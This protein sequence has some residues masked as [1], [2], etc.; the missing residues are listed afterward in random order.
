[1]FLCK[2]HHDKNLS[3]CQVNK[4]PF[5]P[6]TL[7]K[8]K[9]CAIFYGRGFIQTATVSHRI[10]YVARP[11]GIVGNYIS[12]KTLTNPQTVICVLALSSRGKAFL[13]FRI[14]VIFFHTSTFNE[15]LNEKVV[16]SI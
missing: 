16:G 14:G 9:S 11:S 13:A 8:I 7:P 15:E 12:D 6:V 3:S 4:K 2:K 5:S 10:W 1:M